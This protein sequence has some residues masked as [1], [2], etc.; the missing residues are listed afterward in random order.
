MERILKY[1]IIKSK[2]QY[3]NYCKTLEELVF[4]NL[5][6]EDVE[7]KEEI[8]LLTLLIEKWDKENNSF[9]DSDPIELLKD[10]M[11]QHNLKAKDLIDIMGISKGMISSILNYRRGLSKV[12]IRKLASYFKLSQETFNRPYKLISEVNRQYRYSKLMNTQKEITT[13]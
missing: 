11:S 3:K 2:S 9:S 5:T 4:Q 13:G 7:I 6:L 8:E 10:L 1:R 12:S